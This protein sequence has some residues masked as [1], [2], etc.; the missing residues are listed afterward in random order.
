MIYFSAGDLVIEHISFILGKDY[1]ISFGEIK[2]DVYE[3]VRNK[4]RNKGTL[5][6][7][8]GADFLMYSL[9]DAIIDGYF[10]VL[11]DLD[12]KIELLEDQTI[13]ECKTELLYGIREMR[14]TLLSINKAILPLRDVL[15]FMSKE[16]TALIQ[17]T[18]MPYMKDNV[19]HITQAI[20]TNETYREMVVG[21]MDLYYSN[22]SNKL[23]EIMKVLT[24]ISTVFMPLTFIVGVYGM[25][26]K[27]MPEIG[28]K[29]SYLIVWIV[30]LAVIGFMM[31]YFKKKKWF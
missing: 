29:W 24:I 7:K 5:I 8:Q 4:I 6:R 2:G 12:G 23:N 20:E 30:M 17:N 18:T 11:E 27:Y 15:S 14:N 9:M 31:Y 28:F 10:D 26:F 25:N 19:N 16:S 1:M 13:T 3:N 22:T 21:L